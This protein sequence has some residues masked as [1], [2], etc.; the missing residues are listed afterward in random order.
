MS[1]PTGFQDVQTLTDLSV[2]TPLLLPDV[3]V[4]LTDLFRGCQLPTSNCLFPQEGC[5]G[6][7]DKLSGA[8]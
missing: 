2:L 7:F 5:P 6:E 3:T 4:N 1:T 8:L